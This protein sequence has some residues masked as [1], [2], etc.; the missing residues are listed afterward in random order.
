LGSPP[1]LTLEDAKLALDAIRQGALTRK[2]THNEANAASMAVAEWCKAQAAT[3]TKS[4]VNELHAE[5]AEKE[6]QIAE[7]RKQLSGGR[8]IRAVQ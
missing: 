8:G 5:L 2:I 7:L 1:F 3:I 6:K 4:L